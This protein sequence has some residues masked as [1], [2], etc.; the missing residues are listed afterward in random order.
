QRLDVVQRE[1][2]PPALAAGGEQGL[3]DGDGVHGVAVGEDHAVLEGVT[4]APQGVGVVP[5]LGL[6]VVDEGDLQAVLGLQGRAALVD[7]LLAVADDHGGLGE[8]DLGEVGEGEVEHRWFAL[9][10]RGPHRH[11]RLGKAV[12]VGAQTPSGAGRQHEADH[13]GSPSSCTAGA[14]PWWAVT[15]KRMLSASTSRATATASTVS[16]TVN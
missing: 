9:Y 13:A 15:Q 5:L 3:L 12:G 8:A 4:A 11:Q 2:D 16:A 7:G 14:P 10:T 6:V 1:D